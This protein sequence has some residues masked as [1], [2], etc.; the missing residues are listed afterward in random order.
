MEKELRINKFEA[1]IILF[2]LL[3]LKS[4]D[5]GFSGGSGVKSPPAN[6]EDMGWIP[7]LG[8]SHTPQSK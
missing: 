8:K 3:I 5:R 2:Y 6:V 1:G 7:D 4:Y